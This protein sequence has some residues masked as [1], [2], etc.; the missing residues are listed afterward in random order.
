MIIPDRKSYWERMRDTIWQ[1][2][3]YVFGR[4]GFVSNLFNL[5]V[6]LRPFSHILLMSIVFLF[7]GLTTNLEAR[8]IIN[9]Q[10]NELIEGVITGQGEINRINP[11]IPSNN[12]IESDLSRL[13]YE[14]LVTVDMDGN[15]KGVLAKSWNKLDEDGLEYQFELRE[16]VLWHDGESFTADDVLTTFSVLQTLGSGE[17]NIESEQIELAQDV[18]VTKVDKYIF[19]IKLASIR[20]TFFEDISFGILPKHVLDEVS[21]S[22]FTWAK[23]NLR[24]IGTGPFKMKSYR[25]SVIT[26][27]ANTD[28][29]DD[30][31][32]LAQL[33]LKFFQTGDEAVE[34]LKNGQIHT[35]VDPSTAVLSDLDS[36]GNIKV[37][38]S[39]DQY[40]RYMALYFNLK[41]NGPEVFKDKQVRQAISS[42][43]NRQE[44]IEKVETAGR[45]ALGPIPQNSWAYNKDATRYT[46]DPVK[47][48]EIFKKS[49]W[50]QKSVEDEVV[51]MKE[52]EILRFDISYLDKFDRELVAKSIQKDLEKLGVQVNLR[53]LSSSDLNEAQIATR[54]FEAVLYGVKTSIDP[55]RIRLWH[56]NAIDYPGLN[57]AS[58]ETKQKRGV[59]GEEREIERVSIIDAALENALTTLDRQK[60]IGTSGVNVGYARFQEIL[61]DETPAVFLYHPVFT[62]ASHRRVKGVDLSN[63]TV[64]EDRY[65]S[66]TEWYID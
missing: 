58:Y 60:R 4:K 37:V 52:D 19:R 9:F 25:D 39:S 26:L 47:A 10:K 6:T 8:K 49:G 41:E 56:S 65:M 59:I 48:K 27:V 22:T 11:L 18:E 7:I 23:F 64:P 40:R 34:A 3:Q 61:L 43:I 20:P 66:V 42:A 63:M 24:P 30:K 54:N 50:E 31:P 16:D 1:Y 33:K 2:P 57:I 14:P 5:Y 36:W 46:Y 17:S 38:K 51:L 12:Q 35:L 44:I 53:P 13:L 45:E 29:Y 28:Y 55:D 21:L 62:Y 15:V 32:K